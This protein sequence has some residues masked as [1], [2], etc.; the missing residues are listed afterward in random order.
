MTNIIID[1]IS[2]YLGFE[3]NIAI[4]SANKAP[5]S[6]KRYFISKKRGGKRAIFHPSKLTK[7]LQYAFIETILSELPVHHCAAAYV[8]GVKSPLLKN[9]KE[10][11][12]YPYSVRIDFTDFFPSITPNDL[13]VIIKK[14]VKYKN[15]SDEDETFIANALFVT[16]PRGHLG[17]AIGAP[18]SPIIS[19][20]VMFEV[21]EKLTKLSAA[22]SSDSVYTR[23]AD[24]IVFSTAQKGNCAL[25]F[26]GC[27]DVINRI[28]SPK[29]AINSKKTSF[30]S[31]GNRR[32]ITGL[33]ICPSGDVSIGRINKRYIRKL[34]FELKKELLPEEKKKYLSGYLSY[35]LDVEPDFYNRLAIKYGADLVRIAHKYI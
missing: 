33:Y 25:F 19:N 13:I 29:L 11:S 6:Y 27:K 8:R 16:Q 30:S 3:K 14:T 22:I 24:D 20:I 12:V 31:K 1:T 7:S 15:I 35:I 28:T 9:A 34:L 5:T 21:D 32:V 23:Y 2:E 4:V 26:S 18:S 17:L 10:H